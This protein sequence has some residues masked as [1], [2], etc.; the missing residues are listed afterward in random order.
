MNPSPQVIG[1]NV[2]GEVVTP[3]TLQLQA[4]TPLVQAVLAAGGPQTGV[5]IRA[6]RS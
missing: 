3:G 5:L 1:V 4:N 2:I 6:T